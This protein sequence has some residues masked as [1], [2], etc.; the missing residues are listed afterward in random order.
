[1]T[2]ALPPS[3]QRQ[4]ALPGAPA[5]AHGCARA[6][7]AGAAGSLLLSFLFQFASDR[8]WDTPQPLRALFAPGGLGRVCFLC[9]AIWR[10]LGVGAALRAR[11]GR[12]RAEAL[13][14]P[15]RPAARHRGA[16][17]SRQPAREFFP[18]ALPRRPSS[19]WR[20][21]LRRSI[22]SRRSRTRKP[23]KYLTAFLILGAVIALPLRAGAAGRL[24]RA[25][26]VALAGL[27]GEPLYVCDAARTAGPPRGGAGGAFRDHRGA[28]GGF[29]LASADGQLAF[30]RPGGE[31]GAD[32]EECRHVPPPGANAAAAALAQR[33]RRGA[34]RSRIEPALRPDLRQLRVA[35][36]TPGVPA[37]SAAGGADRRRAR[38]LFC[39]GTNATFTGEAVRTWLGVVAGEKPAPLPRCEGSRFHTAPMLLELESTLSF[40]WKDTF[41]LAAAAPAVVR[42]APK[43]DAPPEVE[44]RGLEAAIAVLPGEVVPIDLSATDDYGVQ[45]LWLDWQTAAPSPEARPGRDAR[46]RDR[47]GPAA[48]SKRSAGHYDFSAAPCW[49]SRRIRRCC[50]GRRRW[51]ISRAA[52]RRARRFTAST[53]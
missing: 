19:R 7:L 46:N 30:R 9:V 23:R 11:A 20:A 39:P 14:P 6:A 4:F 36:G 16:G 43:E 5:L 40:A 32:P 49:R 31:R 41:G 27:G 1:M 13:S 35:A 21:K 22:S 26:A 15:G 45:R 48:D 12:D 2:P 53:C 3:L 8:L 50:C 38:C 42:L 17:R 33:G 51:I 29:L 47:R 34:L 18:G 28:G 44:L 24:E 10:A 52:R 37:I 25:A